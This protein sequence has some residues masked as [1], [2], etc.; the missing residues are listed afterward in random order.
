MSAART[1][2]GLLVRSAPFR[3]RSGRD[4][5]DLALAA[6]TLGFDV[7]LYFRGDGALQLLM[8]REPQA[9]GL[10]EGVR[11]WQSLSQL[12]TVSAWVSEAEFRALSGATVRWALDAQPATPAQMAERLAQCAQVLVV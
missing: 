4:Q 3:G 6:G 11:G 2:I 1:R 8:Q 9:A 12:T 10:P 5:L 7:D